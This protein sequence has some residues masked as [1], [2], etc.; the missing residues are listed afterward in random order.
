MDE[1]DRPDPRR[2]RRSSRINYDVL[3]ELQDERVAYAG[4]TVVV[5]LHGALIRTSA[6]LQ[7]GNLVTIHVLRTGKAAQGRIVWA[8]YE[9][10][11]HYG[12]ELH[13][14]SNIWGLTDAPV[15]WQDVLSQSQE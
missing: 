10:S 2:S 14:P 12:V 5:N 9:N 15:D 4:E 7:P 13:K 11:P 8:S 6:I 3:V 1:T